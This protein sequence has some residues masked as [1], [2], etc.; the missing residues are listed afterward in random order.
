VALVVLSPTMAWATFTGKG[1]GAVS[2]GTTTLAAPA[3]LS[4][5]TAPCPNKKKAGNVQVT[6]PNVALA[7]SYTV[8]LD[9]PTSPTVSRSITSGT[10]GTTFALAKG[11]TGTYGV[12]VTSVRGNWTSVAIVRSF[13]C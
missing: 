9:Q 6:F 1:T 8:V 11:E 2:V 5:V 3:S 12:T 7:A 4:V 13:T 10:S